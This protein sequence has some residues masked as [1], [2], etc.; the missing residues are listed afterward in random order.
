M[1]DKCHIQVFKNLYQREIINFHYLFDFSEI[2]VQV[3][4]H[5]HIVSKQSVAGRYFF[6][7]LVIRRMANS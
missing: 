6:K 3:D 5:K 1:P 2:L 4:A 7:A